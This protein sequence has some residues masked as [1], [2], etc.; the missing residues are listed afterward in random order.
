MFSDS[1]SNLTKVEVVSNVKSFV[2]FVLLCGIQTFE[3]KPLAVFSTYLRDLF[4]PRKI[5]MNNTI[6]LLVLAAFVGFASSTFAQTAAP[7]P[8]DDTQFWSDTQVTI[9]LVKDKKK[10]EVVSLL[11]GGT[12]R[13][14]RNITHLVDE[15]G[16]VGFEFN[17]RQ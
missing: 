14:G 16:A 3:A 8:T 10:R 9:K 2:P 11:F 7:Q 12:L 17:L 1:L 13:V 6:V 4:S 5:T 15:R